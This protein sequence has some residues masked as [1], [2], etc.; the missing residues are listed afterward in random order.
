MIFD[1]R[2]LYDEQNFGNSINQQF[3]FWNFEMK[4][5]LIEN[6]SFP[7][8]SK[9]LVGVV[10]GLANLWQADW[11]RLGFREKVCTI[12]K[13]YTRYLDAASHRCSSLNF[14]KKRQRTRR[15]K[16][17]NVGYKIREKKRRKL[18]IHFYTYRA[19]KNETTKTAPPNWI[20]G[21]SCR[22]PQGVGNIPNVGCEKRY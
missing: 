19:P 18:K 11:I 6:F 10:A 17:R 7:C 9:T 4:R 16:E 1:T 21:G 14:A 15:K 12:D 5:K 3:P 22:M 8:P 2:Q 20:Y 13:R